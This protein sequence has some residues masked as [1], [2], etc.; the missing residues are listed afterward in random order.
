MWLALFL[1]SKAG[2]T[3]PKCSKTLFLLIGACQRISGVAGLPRGGTLQCFNS[4]CIL[5]LPSVVHLS[6]E[7]LS[8]VPARNIK[9]HVQYLVLVLASAQNYPWPKLH[10][11]LAFVNV[12][13]DP[14]RMFYHPYQSS[15]LQLRIHVFSFGKSV[16]CAEE[17]F[18]WNS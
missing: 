16:M 2:L 3:I 11:S 8:L 18:Q 12:L 7:L 13:K 15:V 5:S 17:T 6:A 1:V 10:T 9:W 4:D 14:Q